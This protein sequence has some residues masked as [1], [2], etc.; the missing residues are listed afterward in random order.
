MRS[1]LS[2]TCTT[3]EA[4]RLLSV[5]GTCTCVGPYHYYYSQSDME[6]CPSFCTE[7]YLE[8]VL[9]WLSVRR[10]MITVTMR[11]RPVRLAVLRSGTMEG[12]G[13]CW[14]RCTTPVSIVTAFDAFVQVQA[15]HGRGNP[16]RPRQL[17]VHTTT[18]LE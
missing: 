8:G 3:S 7:T 12:I 9:G 13:V 15:S 4:E 17:L 5:A 16:G 11:P 6:M 1:P 10:M 14:R 18:G 2:I